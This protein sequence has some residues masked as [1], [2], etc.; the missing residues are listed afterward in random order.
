MCNLY[1][2]IQQVETNISDKICKKQSKTPPQTRESIQVTPVNTKHQSNKCSKAHLNSK[3]EQ[4]AW[5]QH[6]RRQLA[7]GLS[8]LTG[9]TRNNFILKLK[10]T[11][12]VEFCVFCEVVA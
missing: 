1:S 5:Q 8:T 7:C 6:M 9:G 10:G 4:N 3:S 2:S 11:L 12:A